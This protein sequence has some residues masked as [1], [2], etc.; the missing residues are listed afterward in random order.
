MTVPVPVPVPATEATSAISLQLR[1][2][3]YS[4]LLSGPGIRAIET[5]LD[6][7]LRSTGF[8]D[9]LRTYI[10]FLFRSG[11]ATTAEEAYNL[12][13]HRIKDAMADATASAT[14][15]GDA[16]VDTTTTTTTTITN[17]VNGATTTT[18]AADDEPTPQSA[19]APP[20]V[21][22]KIPNEVVARGT[23]VVMRELAKVCE[24]TYDDENNNNT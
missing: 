18:T 16:D 5:T 10:T 13:M 1:N 6:E 2:N 15:N 11:Q 17:G 8:R 12:A 9:N 3:I 20:N 7:A 22:L 14:A 23:K 4:A 19:E 24:I 21:S